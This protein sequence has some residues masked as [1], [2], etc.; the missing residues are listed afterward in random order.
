MRM[1]ANCGREYKSRIA[2]CPYCQ[3]DHAKGP[4]FVKNPI[5]EYLKGADGNFHER[6]DMRPE[7]DW[8]GDAGKDD[9]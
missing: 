6:K 8:D 7:G 3:Y 2:V 9:S 5:P 1:C 4:F